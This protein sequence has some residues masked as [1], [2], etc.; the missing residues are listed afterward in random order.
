L[1]LHYLTR[2]E[3]VS[4]NP[5]IAARAATF[6]FP[7]GAFSGNTNLYLP[8]PIGCNHILGKIAPALHPI[9][10]IYYISFS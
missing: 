6:H 5:L 9:L 2:K 8:T 4:A 10:V 3:A 7:R 1:C